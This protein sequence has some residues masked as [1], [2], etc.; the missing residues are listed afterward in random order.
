MDNYN[1]QTISKHSFCEVVLQKT[2]QQKMLRSLKNFS[3]NEKICSFEAEKIVEAPNY[4][5]IQINVNQHIHLSPSYL[6]FINHSCEPNV[7]FDTVAM[8]I[9]AIKDIYPGNEFC[10]FYP[11]TELEMKQTFQ[12]NC[13]T[14][15]CIHEIAGA[16]LMDKAILS[17]YKLSPFIQESIFTTI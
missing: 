3:V 10:F 17:T 13:K 8:E 1:A 12:C 6:Q 14:E 11:S 2:N 9:I 5:T 16:A 7:F 4:L 15:K